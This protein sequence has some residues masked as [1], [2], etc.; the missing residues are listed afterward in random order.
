MYG[1][2]DVVVYP[3]HGAGV[4]EKIEER[5]ILGK[6]Q[7][8]YVMKMPYS[9]MKVMIPMNNV[10]NIGIRDV[11]SENEAD[12]VIS[13][14]VSGELKINS[15][16]NKRFRENM[17]KIKSGNIYEVAEVLKSLMM[18][19]RSKGLS[20]GERKMLTSAKQIFISEI[21]LAKKTTNDEIEKTLCS[22]VDRQLSEM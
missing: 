2:G 18:R 16:W 7:K 8:Y 5:E 19:D 13:R 12:A 1:V 11:I 21:V 10:E 14:F 4:I 20:T 6:P 17:V 22:I 9:D 15:N 3:M